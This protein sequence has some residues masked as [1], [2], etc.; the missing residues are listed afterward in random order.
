MGLILKIVFLLAFWFCVSFVFYPAIGYSYV[1]AGELSVSLMG[2]LLWVYVIYEIIRKLRKV[3]KFRME[4]LLVAA[5]IRGFIVL[6]LTQPTTIAIVN[7]GLAT[8]YVCLYF[9]FLKPQFKL[10]DSRFLDVSA[11]GLGEKTRKPKTS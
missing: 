2:D 3:T 7:V 5:V 8:L 9:Q 11:F 6:F 1:E 4:N 10:P